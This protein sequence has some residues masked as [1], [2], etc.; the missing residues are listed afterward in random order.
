[1]YKTYITCLFVCCISATASSQILG[2]G[3]NFS[4]AVLFSQAWITGCP[5]A[6][7]TLSNQAAYEPTTTMDACAPAPACATGTAASDVW[8][9]FYAQAAT[10]TIVAAPSSSLDIAIQAFSG[11]VCPGLTQIGCIDIGGNNVTETLVLT[12]LTTSTLYYFRIF[13]ATNSVAN[14]TGTYTFCGTT[15]VGSAPL[16]VSLGNLTGFYQNNTATLKWETQTEINNLNFEIERSTDGVNFIKAGTVAA[17]GNSNTTKQY[18]FSDAVSA[19][20]LY[21]RLKINDVNGGYKYSS[22]IK[23]ATSSDNIISIVKNPVMGDDLQISVTSTK[24]KM[25]TFTIVNN[26]GSIINSKTIAVSKGVNAVSITQHLPA[27]TY[28]LQALSGADVNTVKFIK[29]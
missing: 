11:S 29:N 13:G 7:S 10:A 23:I 2:G 18:T 27:G 28:L 3:T 24:A 14:Q 6:S 15:Q 4:N 16:A 8:F 26:T 19:A 5:G 17:A 21:Y 1:M 20:V 22:V 12:G 25:V 9:S